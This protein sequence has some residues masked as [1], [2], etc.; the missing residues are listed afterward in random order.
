MDSFYFKRTWLNVTQ[1]TR[2]SVSI[3]QPREDKILL[4]GNM[5]MT[6]RSMND[7][8]QSNDPP[9][10]DDWFKLENVSAGTV[11]IKFT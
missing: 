7:T 4:P 5:T 2:L 1:F 3:Q 9:V 11:S 8:P 6:G 10:G